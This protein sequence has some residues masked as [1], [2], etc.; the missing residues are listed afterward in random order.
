MSVEKGIQTITQSRR[1]VRPCVTD[2]WEPRESPCGHP[3]L[4]LTALRD[5]AQEDIS[6]GPVIAVVGDAARRTAERLVAAE[7][8]MEATTRSASLGRPALVADDDLGSRELTGFVEEELAES[9]GRHLSE[10]PGRVVANHAPPAWGKSFATRDFFG[11]ELGEQDGRVVEAQPA[12][13]LVV[14][15]VDEVTHALA[16][17]VCCL[18]DPLSAAPM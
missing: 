6:G 5:V 14:E 2:T 15:L 12:C 1:N 7:S 11:R 3:P 16:D 17:A 13:K 9:K 4:E 8:M 18:T 10:P